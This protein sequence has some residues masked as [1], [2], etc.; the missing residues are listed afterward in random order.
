MQDL[1]NTPEPPPPPKKKFYKGSKGKFTNKEASR[2]YE[3]EKE[4][5]IFKTN[6]HF[7][8]RQTERL[9]QEVNEEK[10]RADKLQAQINQ[11][12]KSGN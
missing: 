9:A 12:I 8:K 6:Y 4:R 7:Y 3:I 1:F 11:M 2:M 10:Q 5:E